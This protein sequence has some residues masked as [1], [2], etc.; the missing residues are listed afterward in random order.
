MTASKTFDEIES[1]QLCHHCGGGLEGD[2]VSID[3]EYA[4]QDVICLTC[5]AT[6]TEVYLAHHREEEEEEERIEATLTF[7]VEVTLEDYSDDSVKEL[8]L[9]ILSD[10]TDKSLFPLIEVKRTKGVS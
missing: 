10:Q 5:D 7:T 3:G 6:W 1:W 2:Y 8:L 4:R 9:E